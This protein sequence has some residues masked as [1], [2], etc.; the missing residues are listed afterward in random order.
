VA[1]KTSKRTFCGEVDGIIPSARL[2][3]V[4]SKDVSYQVGV[5]RLRLVD[6]TSSDAETAK[7][8]LMTHFLGCQ[9]I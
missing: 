6:F 2:H 7:Y 5:V 3:R 1:K 9:P 4:L 8:L